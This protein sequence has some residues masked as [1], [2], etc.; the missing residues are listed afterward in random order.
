MKRRRLP[1]KRLL[2]GWMRSGIA[3]IAAGSVAGQGLVLLSYPFLTR[4]YDPTE[5]GLLVVF[6]SI[7]SMLG[8]LSTS[9]L[10]AA[11][12]IPK[13]DDQAAAVAWAALASVAVTTGCTALAAWF[14][15]PSVAGM[16]GVPA[17]ADFWWLIALTVA[18]QGCYLVLSEWIVRGRSYGTLGQR[19]LVQGVGQVATQI[20]LGVL[21]ARPLGLLLGS[22]VGRLVGTGGM[23]TRA[24]LLRRHR[25]DLREMVDA[26]RRFRR[27]PLVSSWSKLLNTAGLQVPFLVISATYGDASAGLLGLAVRIIGGPAGVLGQAVYQVFNGESSARLRDSDTEFASFTRRYVMRLLAIGVGPAVLVAVFSPVAFEFVFGAV[28]RD[29]GHFAQLMA[30]VYLAE[31]AVTP[32]SHV[33]RLLERQDLQVAWDAGR[34]ALTVGGPLVCSLVGAP[35]V[36]AVACLA[37]AHVVGYG[38][39]YVLSMHAARESDLARKEAAG[40]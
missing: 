29:A 12:L 30:I 6:T 19:N 7:T 31:F 26:V 39:M 32:I 14:F 36:T 23:L 9:A 24:G 2:S 10:E 4:I 22:A 35:M 28:W 37:V 25:P 20:G 38:S 3:R 5:L 33:L 40:S 8:V 16:L 27:F 1:P 11:V 34:L 15:G 17:L 18:V 21:G 13:S